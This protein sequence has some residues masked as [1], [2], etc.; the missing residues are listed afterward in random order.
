MMYHCDP[1]ACGAHHVSFSSTAATVA[2]H[3][4]GGDRHHIHTTAVAD[5][6]DRVGT[7]CWLVTVTDCC[8]CCR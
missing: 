4:D 8:C 1:S 3:D 2:D 7:T 6:F 5:C